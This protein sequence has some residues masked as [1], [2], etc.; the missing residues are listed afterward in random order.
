MLS[1]LISLLVLCAVVV[2]VFWLLT[3][4]PIPQPFLNIVK[5]VIILI[6]LFYVLGMLPGLSYFHSLYR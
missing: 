3:I 1:L 6:C 5:V 4:L 2:V